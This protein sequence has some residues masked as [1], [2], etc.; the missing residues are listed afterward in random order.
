[1]TR[2]KKINLWII[3]LFSL[4]MVAG[5]WS[6]AFAATYTI[7]KIRNRT[8]AKSIS[9]L[10]ISSD[11]SKVVW[12][13]DWFNVFLYDGV[14]TTQITNSS[15]FNYN[16]YVTNDGKIAWSGWDAVGSDNDIFYY[17]GLTISNIDNNTHPIDL[18]TGI[19]EAGQVVGILNDSTNAANKDTFFFNGTSFTRLSNN[20]VADDNIQLNNAGQSVWEG[21][22]GQDFEI[23]YHDGTTTTQLTNN[24]VDDLGSQI[25]DNGQV[26]WSGAGATGVDGE[27]FI[28][29]VTTTTTTQITD[30]N[31]NNVTPEINASGAV[32]WGGDGDIFF[33]DGATITQVTNNTFIEHSPEI[34]NNGNMIWLGNIGGKDQLFYSNGTTTT[35]LSN[36]NFLR[37]P[38]FNAVNSHVVWTAWDGLNY[39]VHVHDGVS[40]TQLTNQDNTNLRAYQALV[41]DIGDVIWR[42][43][44]LGLG[45]DSI[46]IARIAPTNLLP[47]A[48]AGADQLAHA[49]ALVTLDG[50]GSNDA[51]AN[52]PLTYAWQITTL[53]AGSLAALS[54]TTVASPS[55]TPD[56]VG[57]YTIE[58]IV[59][60]SLGGVSAPDTVLVKTSNA[61]P[62]ADAGVDQAVHA[63]TLATLDGSASS[64][65]DG[66]Y[67]LTYAWQI[68][69][70]PAGSL[71]TLSNPASVIPSFIV[72]AEGD[73]IIAL[74]VTDNLGAVSF[75]DTVLV[76]TY[77]TVPV[78]SAGLDQFTHVGV[79]VTLDG[80]GSSDADGDPFTYSW[81]L[82][83]PLGSNAAL[84]DP[85]SANPSF[86]P[87]VLG[88]YTAAL[89]VTDSLGAVSLTDTVVVSADNI[90]P[91]ANAGFNQSSHVRTVITLDGSGSSDAEGDP[92]TYSWSLLKPAGST[93]VLSNPASA[94]PSFTADLVGDYTAELIVTDSLGAVSLPDTVVVSATNTAPV[95]NAGVDQTIHVGT[96]AT[97]NGIGSNDIDADYPLAYAWQITSQPAGST[98]VLSNSAS[99]TPSF[100]P[101][102]VGNYTATLIVTDSVGAVSLPDTVV[103]SATNTAPVANAGV[104]QATNAG[105]TVT[106]DGSSSSDG[107]GDALTYSWSLLSQPAGS[108]AVLSNPSSANPSFTTDVVG[109]YTAELIVTDSLGAVSISDTVVVS[110]TNTAPV[111]NA[112]V[113]HNAV[114]GDEIFFDGSGSSDLEGDQLTYS[115][116]IVSQPKK[117]NATLGEATSVT[118]SLIPDI[119]GTY[120]VSLVVN[121]GFINSTPASATLVAITR[122][123]VAVGLL[124][125][126]ATIIGDLTR[127]DVR[128]KDASKLA[129][130]VNSVIN[131]I[132]A[133]LYADALATLEIDL[134]KK[135]DGC[136][137]KGSPD[138][139]DKI[140]TCEAQDQVYPLLTQARTYM[141]GM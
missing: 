106:L 69:L 57:D 110:A 49:G 96:L 42:D 33:Y 21:W 138:K 76:T 124:S 32:V 54:D 48:N 74:L 131:M 5:S 9:Y 82:T 89:V 16:P 83:T 101:D 116:S 132:G 22:D 23:F 141:L 100:T 86:T 104:D 6:S 90:A 87:D 47:S 123:A 56:M 26:V 30:D 4:I 99:S 50:S 118:A 88:D 136:A 28:Y 19:N 46:Y 102:V 25:N 10:N 84:S 31:I 78:A 125:E 127:P 79:T 133:G 51:D 52:Y 139:K 111:A 95:A 103:V 67:P 114:A 122:Q 137:L 17:D 40:T 126:A 105:F 72:D 112:G 13:E 41:S 66:D 45:E 8:P 81:L 18:V 15:S 61:A 34:S 36:T 107:D 135:T 68:T 140:K 113:D 71:A 55:F 93:A 128:G 2:I 75:E 134:I 44:D 108:T 7:T 60:D 12:S 62:V 92:F 65:A 98:A 58:L 38:D 129:D 64:D 109:D 24:I 53:P 120:V 97:L 80:S 91:V 115:W 35:Q 27:I 11:G 37:K 121:D 59:T 73:Y 20:I 39:E 94:S 85:A 117:S 1:M 43:E 63:G 14:N 77:N 70:K 119:G 3:F 29:D 130:K